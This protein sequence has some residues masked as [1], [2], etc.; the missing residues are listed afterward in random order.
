VLLGETGDEDTKAKVNELRANFINKVLPPFAR[1]TK[2]FARSYGETQSGP[3]ARW[4]RNDDIQGDQ[5]KACGY[6][7]VPDVFEDD[8]G[9][10]TLVHKVQRKRPFR[11]HEIALT[12]TLQLPPHIRTVY[13]W[14]DP[15]KIEY[16]AKHLR[17]RSKELAILEYLHTKQPRS[18]HIIQLIEAIPSTTKEWLILPKMYSICDKILLNSRGT[19]GRVQLGL[20]LIKGLAYLHEHNIAHRDIKPDNLVCDEYFGLQIIDF[21]LAIK[22]QDENTEIGEYRGTKGWTA[23]EMGKEDGPTPM[24]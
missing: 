14:R 18:P 23:P 16:I 3:G 15:N 21:D 1:R 13:R 22:V 8:G 6:K 17:K 24:L 9:T 10:W 7:V 19:S 2:R 11:T 4:N 20:G 5:L 12:M